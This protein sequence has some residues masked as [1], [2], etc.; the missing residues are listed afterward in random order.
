[1]SDPYNRTKIPTETP[2]LKYFSPTR[3]IRYFVYCWMALLEFQFYSSWKEID[4]KFIWSLFAIAIFH[5]LPSGLIAG[6]FFSLS[7]GWIIVTMICWLLTQICL[8]LM[9]HL[10]DEG[11]LDY[12]KNKLIH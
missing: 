1:M 2:K 8:F 11:V 5:F 6:L 3:P 7:T 12:W 10:N 4:S 9:L